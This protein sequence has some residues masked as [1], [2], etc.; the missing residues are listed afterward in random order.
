M[1]K[2]YTYLNFLPHIRKITTNT[3][4]ELKW[5]NLYTYDRGKKY[6]SLYNI[7]FKS[8]CFFMGNDINTN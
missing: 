6:A 5:F 7:S 8:I 4:F 2:K 3:W 1:Q